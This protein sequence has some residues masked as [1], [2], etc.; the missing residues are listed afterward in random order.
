MPAFTI[1][2]D[3][4]PWIISYALIALGAYMML[5]GRQ[6]FQRITSLFSAFLLFS[7]VGCLLSINGYFEN[8][9]SEGPS[10]WFTFLIVVILALAI[11][12]GYL[13]GSKLNLRAALICMSVCNAGALCMLLVSFLMNFTGSWIM[14]VIS[15]ITFTGVCVYLPLKFE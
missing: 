6:H 10:G 3:Q 15:S 2:V 8:K 11:T 4:W 14:L 9:I 5:F 7:I 13:L 1:F 12:L